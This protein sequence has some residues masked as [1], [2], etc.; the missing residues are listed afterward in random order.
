MH[1]VSGTTAP[2]C[3]YDNVSCSRAFTVFIAFWAAIN[4]YGQ[5]CSG[6]VKI[7]SVDTVINQK[8]IHYQ[9]FYIQLN[10][11][12]GLVLGRS[13]IECEVV[14]KDKTFAIL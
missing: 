5:S 14:I 12:K 6:I 4:A 2:A 11:K 7:N 8:S 13:R 1:Q 10:H 9:T 3:K